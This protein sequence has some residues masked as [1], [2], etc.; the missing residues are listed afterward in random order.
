MEQFSACDRERHVNYSV[1]LCTLRVT[2]TEIKA[3]IT[4][5]QVGALLMAGFGLTSAHICVHR[6]VFFFRVSSPMFGN[7]LNFLQH[8]EAV[9]SNIGTCYTCRP[10]LIVLYIV[11]VMS[12]NEL[13]VCVSCTL[14]TQVITHYLSLSAKARE[15]QP[16]LAGI[17]NGLLAIRMIDSVQYC[18]VESMRVVTSLYL[19][20]SEL[21]R[22]YVGGNSVV[23]NSKTGGPNQERACTSL[24]EGRHIV[25]S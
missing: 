8:K 2:D 16:V 25:R 5:L 19:K 12:L 3:E 22:C 4:Q 15:K 11:Y 21:Q 23:L 18:I 9:S 17:V 6:I 10:N 14:T 1:L 7:Y 20:Y 24:S 13:K